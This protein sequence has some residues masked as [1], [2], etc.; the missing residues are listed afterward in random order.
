[1]VAVTLGLPLSYGSPFPSGLECSETL[2]ALLPDFVYIGEVIAYFLNI[3][4]AYCHEVRA[5]T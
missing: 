2:K 5:M 4:V 1:M 3:D